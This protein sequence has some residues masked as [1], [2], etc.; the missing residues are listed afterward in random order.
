MAVLCTSRSGL[1]PLRHK[2][3]ADCQLTESNVM[4]TTTSANPRGAP[5]VGPRSSERGQ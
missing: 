5:A 4:L 3:S 2:L 1:T